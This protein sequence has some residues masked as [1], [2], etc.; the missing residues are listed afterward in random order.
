M[1]RLTISVPND[2]YDKIINTA[3]INDDSM[4]NTIVKMTG[5]GFLVTEN[6]KTKSASGLSEIE[7]HCSK[8]II[9]MNALVKEMAEEKLDYNRDKF[10]SLRDKAID[11]FNEIVGVSHEEL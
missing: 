7:E 9:Q 3:K 1:P 2:L 8:L 6:N 11:R 10:N 4:S 5:L